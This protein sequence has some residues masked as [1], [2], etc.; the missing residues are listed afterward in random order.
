MNGVILLFTLS[1]LILLV[2]IVDLLF[3]SIIGE[4]MK[5]EKY[6]SEIKNVVSSINSEINDSIIEFIAENSY[7]ESLE[8]AEFLK[9]SLLKKLETIDNISL[10][11]K[12]FIKNNI[13]NIIKFIENNLDLIL[14]NQL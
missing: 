10:N 7:D 13:D 5:K 11:N 2:P 9:F 8:L 14:L 4:K 3:I 1:L 6:E 12:F